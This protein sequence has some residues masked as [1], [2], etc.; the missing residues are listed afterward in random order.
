M[1]WCHGS[2]ILVKSQAVIK[3]L[4]VLKKGGGAVQRWNELPWEE[5][6]VLPVVRSVWT[7]VEWL[8]AGYLLQGVGGCIPQSLNPFP[9]ETLS[10]LGELLTV[11]V[12][13]SETH[14]S[15]LL[16][17]VIEAQSRHRSTWEEVVVRCG[18]PEG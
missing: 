17:K 10:L 8:L 5:R 11:E 13:I 3:C 6:S 18:Q 16:G 9:P 4:S 1:S 2:Y 7:G 15:V 14:E 12:C